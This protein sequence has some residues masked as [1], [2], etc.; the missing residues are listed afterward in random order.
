MFSVL[1][2]S[3]GTVFPMLPPKLVSL[4]AKLRTG[5]FFTKQ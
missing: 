3:L 1:F 2:S 5:R 4:I